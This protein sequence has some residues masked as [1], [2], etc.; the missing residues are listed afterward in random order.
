MQIST[1]KHAVDHSEL[2]LPALGIGITYSSA[3]EPLLQQHPELFDVVEIEPQTMWLETRGSPQPYRIVEHVL[4]HISQLPGRKIV[5]SI[6]APVGGTVRPDPVQLELLRRTIGYLNAPWLS[7]H[8][9]FNATPEFA[10]G[11]FLP[12]RQTSQGVDTAVLAIRDL[13]E[14]LPIPVAVETG[15]NYLQPR[16]DEMPDAAFVAAV[17]ET[18]DCGILLD[19]HNIFTNAVN[20][21][22]SVDEFLAQI[23]LD[24]VWELHLAGGFEMDGFWLDA[25]SGA[26]PDALM[27]IV[28]RIMPGLPNVKAVI[29]EIFPSFVSTVG[30]DAIRHQIEKLHEL[31]D[32]RRRGVWP[33]VNYPVQRQTSVNTNERPSPAAW[34][35]ALGALVIGQ[36]L[37]GDSVAHELALDPGVRLISRL[38]REFRASMIVSVL[39][40]TSRLMMLSLG[41]DVFRAIL[42]DF[43]S[44]IPPQQFGSSEAEAF[45]DYLQALDVKVPQLTKVLEFERAVLDTLVD[46]QPRIVIF[47]MDPLP[48][49][50][51]LGE[52]RLPDMP[53][54]PGR[55]E[56]EVTS[57]GATSSMG[58]GL[59]TIRDVVPFH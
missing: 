33:Q 26:I 16:S 4:E 52:G 31:W 56:F 18:A 25:H 29:F 22:Q 57:D 15:V 1:C 51:A 39:R 54:Q 2:Q 48:L 41:P 53:S 20:G 46:D 43:W 24:R 59:S 50:R 5:H 10:T 35:R 19:L 23:P 17:V 6:G 58:Q 11:F 3:I 30:L 44:K 32:G 21:R 47:D 27:E 37:Q 28:T 36:T 13:K 8:L 14:S 42:A 12:P 38:I 49:L 9:S 34:E 40:L 55:F 7:E 45:A